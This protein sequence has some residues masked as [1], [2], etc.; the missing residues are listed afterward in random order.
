MHTGSCL[1]QAVRYEYQGEPVQKSIC[2]CLTCR[3]LCSGASTNILIPSALFNLTSGKVK[4][5]TV[6]HESGM[7]LTASFCEHC[8][9]LLYKTADDPAFECMV[10]L[11]VGT[12]DEP[13]TFD[14]AAPDTEQYIGYRAKW[15]PPLEYAAQKEGFS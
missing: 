2:H 3:K 9:V 5:Y 4:H 6:T 7:H 12:L 10:V 11:Q 15:R 13:D 1:C 14:R 8:G